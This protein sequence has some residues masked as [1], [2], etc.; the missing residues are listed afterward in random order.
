MKIKT[1]NERFLFAPA[2]RNAVRPGSRALAAVASLWTLLPLACLPAAADVVHYNL[3][4]DWSDTQ[5]PNGAWSCN[6]NNTPI[7]VYQT[8]WWGQPG[9]GYISIGDGSIIKAGSYPTGVTDPWGGVVPPPH[10]WLPGDVMIH[11]LS[12]VYGGSSTWVNVTWT[13]P[14]DGTID[15][16]G[17][18]WEGE[19]FDDRDLGWSLIVGG[20]TIA[21]RASVSGLYRTDPGA[22]FVANLIGT[23]TLTGIPVVQGEVVQFVGV[24]NT[25][26]GQWLGVDLDIALNVIPEPGA[27][28]LLAAGFIGLWLRR[29]R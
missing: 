23:H 11:P 29:R 19:I 15:I 3:V 9:W 2:I 21:Q 1:A 26:Y 24:A 6:W 5:N 22:Q 17:R 10:D 20:E 12:Q 13:S 8:F 4:N 18:A 16:T 27:L 7:S 25:Y 28:P 14:A